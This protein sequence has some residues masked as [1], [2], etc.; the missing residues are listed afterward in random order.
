MDWQSST[1]TQKVR[2]EITHDYSLDAL[3]HDAIRPE[4]PYILFR[5]RL[6]SLCWSRIF[7]I[8]F[9]G[10]ALIALADLAVTPLS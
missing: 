4:S 9:P 1:P 6:I 2:L 7:L 3:C 10:F 8:V 5:S